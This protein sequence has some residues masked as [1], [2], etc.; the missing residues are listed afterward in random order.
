V[1]V[2]ACPWPHREQ[3]GATLAHAPDETVV[4]RCGLDRRFLQGFFGGGALVGGVDLQP[5]VAADV[6]ANGR[7]LGFGQAGQ[8]ALD[9][10]GASIFGQGGVRGL[11]VAGQGGGGHAGH[12]RI[13]CQSFEGSRRMSKVASTGRRRPAREAGRNAELL[14]PESGV[15]GGDRVLAPDGI[16]VG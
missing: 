6:P 2:L 15:M 16:S 1:S 3:H 5:A 8:D 7:G 13:G 14:L 11:P 4:E 9:V 10:D 12:A